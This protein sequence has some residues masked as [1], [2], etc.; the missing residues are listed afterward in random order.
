MAVSR[1]TPS[2]AARY[3]GLSAGDLVGLYR[4]MYTSRRTD[5]EEIRLKKLDKI[6]FQIS[7]AGHEAVLAA[8]GQAHAA[9]VRL[10]LSLLPRPRAV[11]AARHDAARRCCCRR[12]PPPE[13]PNSGGRQM[14]SHWGHKKLNIVSQS[15][16]T[17]TQF[18]QAV[19]AAE[20]LVKYHELEDATTRSCSG[21]RARRRSRASH[22][23]RRH[24]QRGRVLGGDEHRLQ[25]QAAGAVP[26][27][28][29]RLRDLGAGGRADRRRQRR[30]AGANFPNLH[31][32]GE[33]DGN[34][35]VE[36]YGILARGGRRTAARARARRSS[37][38]W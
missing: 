14:P 35:P 29:Q 1:T 32:V 27:R 16:P 5:D 17:G 28:G 18:L 23:R 8:A 10:V 24:H 31:W 38:R 15:S 6:F 9:G 37:A 2:A 25:S 4:T 7:G 26:D 19:G 12:S 11:P 36:S 34:D 13:D 20:A 3:H 22:R 30:S 33:I 21:Q